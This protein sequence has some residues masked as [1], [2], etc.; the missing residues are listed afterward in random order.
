METL[1]MDL[2]MFAEEEETAAASEAA[3]VGQDAAAETP[4]EEP[5]KDDIPE[6]LDGLPEEIA[7]EV[8]AEAN[9][10][11]E[12][13]KGQ[14]EGSD[15]DQDS[16]NKPVE[17]Q[18]PEPNQKIPYQRFKQQVDK[19]N[20][21]EAQLAAYRQKFGDI[22]APAPAAQQQPQQPP[23][24]QPVQ[25]Q[26]QM[27]QQPQSMA[28]SPETMSQIQNLVKQRAMQI[29]G[30]TQDDVD[31]LEYA[32]EN[33]QRK[34][35]WKNALKFA[36]SDVYAGIRQAQMQRAQEVQ[37]IMQEHE[38]VVTAFNQYT[39]KEQASP[40]FQQIQAYATDAE[41]GYPSKL[42]QNDRNIIVDAYQR[43]LR[44]TASAQDVFLVR[45]YYEQ[46]KADYFA[47]KGKPRPA[48]KPTQQKAHPRSEQISGA[49]SPD[50]GVSVEQLK[51]MLLNK[52]WSDIPEKYRNMM[53][54]L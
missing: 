53:K 41:H 30:M 21:L 5:P 34:G 42:S 2:Q 3:D 28:F 17:E 40:E 24:A 44:N 19:A 9:G 31:S 25:Q 6:E 23:A 12:D 8:M 35:A 54:G 7:R 39:E 18:K 47:Q 50:G 37:R 45:N 16:D 32:D 10:K 1:M 51:D 48:N 20:D 4:A 14:A 49:S 52:E 26:P 11:A 46:A 38:E 43:I 36:E 22:N 29:M 13:G 15:A 33:D 27:A